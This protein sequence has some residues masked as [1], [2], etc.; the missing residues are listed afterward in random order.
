M[1]G[2]KILIIVASIFLILLIVFFTLITRMF[3]KGGITDTAQTNPSQIET[4]KYETK[5]YKNMTIEEK[6]KEA[7]KMK[8][9]S[10]SLFT[11]EQKANLQ[12]LKNKL[13]NNKTVETDDFKLAYSEVTN[14]FYIQKKSPQAEAKLKEYLNENKVLD[15][16]NSDPS[17]FVL[18]NTE[19]KPYIAKQEDEL[20]DLLFEDPDY[21]ITPTAQKKETTP[22]ERWQREYE[23][24]VQQSN[25]IKRFFSA[26][27]SIGTP[28]ENGVINIGTNE[29]E[30]STLETQEN[31]SN[32]ERL[33]LTNEEE[34][35]LYDLIEELPYESD[36]FELSYSEEL[37][38]FYY[39]PITDNADDA[40]YDFLLPYANTE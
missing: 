40:L 22:E 35:I 33:N 14:Q 20:I 9:E 13:K 18:I 38:Q 29:E 39:Y 26:L 24:R 37:N 5:G 8:K 15:I 36:D 23:K 3:K 31:A 7:I 30:S 16:Y 11:K 32:F 10:E 17:V 27:T 1:R 4:K 2:T 28:D 34:N 6:R 21:S 12:E 19:L 25:Q